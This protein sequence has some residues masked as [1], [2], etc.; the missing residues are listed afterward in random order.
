MTDDEFA[1]HALIVNTI[2]AGLL[3]QQPALKT[4][5]LATLSVL[6][7]Q[8]KYSGAKEQAI[9]DEAIRAINAL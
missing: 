6:R 2:L 1:V 3:I 9:I 8:T 5:A 4:N 7:K